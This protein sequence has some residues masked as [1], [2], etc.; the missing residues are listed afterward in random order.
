MIREPKP[1]IYRYRKI[2]V[3]ADTVHAARY[4]AAKEDNFSAQ[5]TDYIEYS[6]FLQRC[7]G[8]NQQQPT[9]RGGNF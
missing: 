7:S 8:G 1:G 5:P 3:Y 2:Y 4:Y 6:V 9:A